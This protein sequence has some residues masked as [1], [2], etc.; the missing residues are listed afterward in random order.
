MSRKTNEEKRKQLGM[1]FGTAA[2]QL[3]KSLL[4]QYVKLAKGAICF[5]CNKPID[6][7]EEFSIEHKIPWLHSGNAR[8]LFFDLNNIAFSHLFCN[9]SEGYRHT[10]N[11]PSTRHYQPLCRCKKCVQLEKGR[12]KKMKQHGVNIRGKYTYQRKNK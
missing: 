8:K 5:H 1:P 10:Q 2:G 12:K 3:R 4:F 7:I 6:T 9:L 11:H